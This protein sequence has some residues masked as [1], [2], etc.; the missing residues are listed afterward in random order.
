MLWPDVDTGPLTLE[1][2][3]KSSSTKVPRSE[4]N[5]NPVNSFLMQVLRYEATE[6]E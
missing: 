3:P 5:M 1:V 2:D 4:S 6:S